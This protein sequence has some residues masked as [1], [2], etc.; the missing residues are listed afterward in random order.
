MMD[1]TEKDTVERDLK[2]MRTCI[3]QSGGAK[4]S[5]RVRTLK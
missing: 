3:E 4:G 1:H 5:A 2:K